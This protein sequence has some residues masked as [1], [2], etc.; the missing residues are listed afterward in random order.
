MVGHMPTATQPEPTQT[1]R[2]AKQAK[3]WYLARDE[4][5]RYSISGLIAAVIFF[6]VD[7]ATGGG[8]VSAIGLAVIL[9]M[10]AI[11]ISFVI[12]RTITASLRKRS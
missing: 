11:A 2:R 4:T 7:I 6:V 5:D 10:F 3:A 12:S 8:V 9:G 1:N